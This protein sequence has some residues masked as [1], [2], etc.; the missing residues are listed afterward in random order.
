MDQRFSRTAVIG[1]AFAFAMPIAL[2]KAEIKTQ[3]IDYKQGDATLEGY[4]AY[5]DTT[6]A[7][8]PG[9]IVAHEW[10]GLT[11]YEKMRSEMLAKLGFVAFAADIYGKSV[12]PAGVPEKM[13]QSSKYSNDRALL[14][15]RMTA[16]LDML[17]RDARVD[18]GKIAAI[19]FCFGGTAVLELARSGAEIG[20][21]V[22]FHGGLSNPSPQDDR[23]IRGRVLVLHGADDPLVP[24]AAVDALE[25]Q[26]TDAKVDWQVV[27]YSG[28]VHS[29][30]NP[31]SNDPA[32]GVLYNERSDVRSW[33]AMQD[34][35][36]EAFAK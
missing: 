29:F 25:K 14:R 9:I 7:R 1:F 13:A 15:A 30:T 35:L 31:A 24:K 5:D 11:A 3:T 32:H 20:G 4:L 8:R 10:G 22:T 36:R 28:T 27:L 18:T 17:G 23:N 12:R 19:G 16:A 2:A 21:V 33:T 6:A 34:F 26:L